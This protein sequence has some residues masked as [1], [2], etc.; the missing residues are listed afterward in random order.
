[1]LYVAN[2]FAH[3]FSPTETTEDEFED[4][5]SLIKNRIFTELEE[6]AFLKEESLSDKYFSYALNTEDITEDDLDSYIKKDMQGMRNDAIR[7]VRR[8]RNYLD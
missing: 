1:M 7:Y 5:I 8:N 3:K 4:F 6:I 2:Y